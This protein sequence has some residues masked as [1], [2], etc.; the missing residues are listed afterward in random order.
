MP[1][2]TSALPKVFWGMI[3]PM[4]FDRGFK[5]AVLLVDSV[6]DGNRHSTVKKINFKRGTKKIITSHGFQPSDRSRR[7]VKT[8]PAHKNGSDAA[9]R[10]R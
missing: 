1:I 9:R 3:A 8:V 4:I 5:A 10:A 6:R 2:A 7:R